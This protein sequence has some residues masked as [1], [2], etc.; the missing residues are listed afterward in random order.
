MHHNKQ[1]KLVV[2]QAVFTVIGATVI[3]GVAG[4][5]GGSSSSP[6]GS[7]GKASSY[8]ASTPGGTPVHGGTA[9]VDSSESP[10][11][12][13][14]DESEGSNPEIRV[15][16]AMYNELAEVVRGSSEPQPAL[17]SSWTVSPNATVYTFHIRPGVKFSNGEPLKGEDVVYT[18]QRLY[19]SP[20]VG[21]VLVKRI[22]KISLLGPM[23]VQMQL[24]KAEPE[25][26]SSVA[27]ALSIVPKHVVANES[28]QQFAQHPIGT[29]P[30][31]L[32]STTTGNTTVTFVRNPHYWHVGL[33]YLNGMVL[34]TVE[35][36][37]ARILAVRSGTSTIGLSIP[38]S[39]VSALKEVSGVKMLIAPVWGAALDEINN[40][41][42]PL[43]EAN[44]RRALMYA[45]PFAEIVKTV[46][47]GLTTQANS[48]LG[49]STYRNPNVPVYKYNLAKAKE[50]LK[51][52]SVPNGFS[53][54]INILGGE[55]EGELLASILQ[56]AWAKIGVHVSIHS[57]EGAAL[58]TGLVSGKY[59]MDILP[60]EGGVNPSF[61]GSSNL[62]FYLTGVLTPSRVPPPRLKANIE[63]EE[64][65]TNLS[66]RR[67]L[68]EQIQ[69]ESYVED[70]YMI[71][72]VNLV[73]LTLV[74]DSLRGFEVLPNEGVRME[75]A[76]L[77]G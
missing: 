63:K 10:A 29:G 34:N 15:A 59:Q 61:E 48:V 69:Y 14:V 53:L 24:Y 9:V 42:P 65:A 49:L 64:V 32:K 5:G 30:F 27:C 71:P 17:A 23:T 67:K 51:T 13:D 56:S 36:S 26:I 16:Y 74:S 58:E 50:L 46:F 28:A 25:F 62:V 6:T 22:K 19:N 12:L 7:S 4:C 39:Q 66:E 57:L 31:M 54:T 35:S 2:W 20:G 76:W 11:T 37:N 73:S 60:P 52:T 45:T 47:K 33:P 18:Y 40:A 43:N 41:K 21:S 72:I 38:Y 68:F 44:V 75:E 8:A 70:P 77:A 55:V 3:L 1:A